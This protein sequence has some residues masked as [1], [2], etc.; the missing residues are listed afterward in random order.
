MKIKLSVSSESYDKIKNELLERGIEIDDSAELVLSEVG[1]YS[2]YIAV[3]DASEQK[4]L[5]ISTD[6][7]IYIEAFGHTVEVHTEKQVYQTSD[8]L[9]QLCCTLDP[10]RFL[11]I[12][13]SVIIARDKVKQINPTFS[14][15]FV[16]VMSNNHKVDVTRSYYNI[17]KDYF[18]I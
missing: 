1:K 4:K 13:N 18:G 17:F 11:R 15:K 8:R 6:D 7:I 9:Y 10:A 3:R 14:M 12:S 2:N 5:H 16:L